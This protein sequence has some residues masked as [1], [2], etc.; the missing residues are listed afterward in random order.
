ML[1]SLYLCDADRGRFY[2]P[3]GYVR[4]LVY[5]RQTSGAPLKNPSL[6]TISSSCPS[7]DAHVH[8][9][10]TPLLRA[11]TPRTCLISKGFLEMPL[12]V[13]FIPKARLTASLPDKGRE[14]EPDSGLARP[15]SDPLLGDKLNIGKTKIIYKLNQMFIFNYRFGFEVNKVQR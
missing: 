2:S 10:Y 3:N 6:R 1:D 5:L 13:R 4:T 7:S 9:K 11:R 14:E 15:E 12:I 8:Q